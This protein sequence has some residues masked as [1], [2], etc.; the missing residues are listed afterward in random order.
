MNIRATVTSLL[1]IVALPLLAGCVIQ[2]GPVSAAAQ[3][4]KVEEIQADADGASPIQMASG[5][6]DGRPPRLRA[7][8]AMSYWVW[9]GAK[10]EWHVRSTS[11]QLHRFQG[12][13]RPL[14][15]A[16][17]GNPKATRLEWGDRMRLQGKDIVFDF[18]TKGGEDGFDFTLNGNACVDMDL[19]IDG[20]SHPKLIVIGKTEQA[21]A[22]S[23]FIACP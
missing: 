14:D 17:L 12:R 10:G 18:S 5:L 1:P 22:S 21:P 2:A 23:H 8:A 19:R 3:S 6:A 4:G 15:G 16:T 9:Q 7:S 11:Q 13:I 20:T